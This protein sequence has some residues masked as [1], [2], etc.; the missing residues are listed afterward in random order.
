MAI[1][2]QVDPA[3]LARSFAGEIRAIPE[4]RLL[5]Y[6]AGP[7][8]VDPGKLL[9]DLSILRNPATDAADAAVADPLVRLAEH[10]PKVGVGLESFLPSHVET[11]GL[12]ELLLRGSIEIPLRG[13]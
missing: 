13:G 5:R 7:D 4:V 2:K 11:L 8:R 10:H 3:A 12:D 1:A 6:W 9:L